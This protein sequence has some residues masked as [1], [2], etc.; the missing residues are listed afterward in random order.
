MG[1]NLLNAHD[2]KE[3]MERAGGIKHTKVAVVE[4]IPGAGIYLVNWK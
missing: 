4:I 2:V 1:N 3:G